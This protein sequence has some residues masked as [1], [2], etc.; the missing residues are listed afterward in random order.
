[1]TNNNTLKAGRIIAFIGLAG[2]AI[3]LA[4]NVLG[5]VVFEKPSASFFADTWW[6]VWSPA[7]LVWLSFSV[8]G[9]ALFIA[10]QSQ[11]G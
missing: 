8:V 11:K 9:G 7:Y 4:L 1:M 2:L 6:S 10:G 3:A 5:I